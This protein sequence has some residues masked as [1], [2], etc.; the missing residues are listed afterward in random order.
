MAKKKSGHVA[1]PFLIALLLGIVGIGGVAMFVFQRISYKEPEIKEM[2]TSVI[3]PTAADNMTLLFVLDEKENTSL[4]TTFMVARVLPVN[5]KIIFFCFPSNMLAVVDGQNDTLSSFYSNSG[6]QA[7]KSAIANQS[8]IQIDRYAILDSEAFQK[9]C[10]IYAGVY[11]QVPAG[12]G[13]FADSAEPQYLGP[14][15]ME[16]LITYPFYEQGEIQRSALAADVI[17]DMVNQTDYERIVSRMDTN[18]RTLVNMMDTDITSVDYSNKESALKY[19]YNYGDMIASFRI[20]TG[21]SG[22]NEDV[23]LLSDNFYNSVSDL[24]EEQTAPEET[25]AASEPEA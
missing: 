14:S 22:E 11:Y 15:Q 2:Q 5:K 24:F 10:N 8:G 20:V 13:G 7:V 25:T 4:P 1:I 3:K 23:F 18:F 21:E 16:K 19:M 17:A 9:I 12:T 6:I